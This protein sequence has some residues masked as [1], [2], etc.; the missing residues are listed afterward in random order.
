MQRLTFPAQRPFP[1]RRPLTWAYGFVALSAA[2]S[3][4][5]AFVH[6]LE[7]KEDPVIAAEMEVRS[8]TGYGAEG[9]TK[10]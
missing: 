2:C 6:P 9:A 5:F 4:L 1:S 8:L 10:H 3:I 7:R